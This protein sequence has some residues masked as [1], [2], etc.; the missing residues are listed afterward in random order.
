VGVLCLVLFR[1]TNHIVAGV[2][3]LYRRDGLFNF[4]LVKSTGNDRIGQ[5]LS[6]G[7][8]FAL[9]QSKYSRCSEIYET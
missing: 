5:L 1:T 8:R 4:P 9:G 6:K 7:T 2:N 3:Y